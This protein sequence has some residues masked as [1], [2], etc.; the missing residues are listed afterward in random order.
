MATDLFDKLAETDVPPAPA[1]LDRAVHQR[2]NKVLVAGHLIDFVL[3]ALPYAAMHML[4]GLAHWLALTISGR[5][6]DPPS[7]KDRN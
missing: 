5:P 1:R 3:R 2:L 7:R 6:L 4:A